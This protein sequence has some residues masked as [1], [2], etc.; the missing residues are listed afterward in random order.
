MSEQP[1]QEVLMRWFS[2]EDRDRLEAQIRTLTAERDELR[3]DNSRHSRWEAEAAQRAYDFEKQLAA[4]T[5][6]LRTIIA[7]WRRSCELTRAEMLTIRRD[8]QE[9]PR[10][11]IAAVEG[12]ADDLERALL[13]LTKE[14]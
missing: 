6:A 10:Y 4:L 1:D 12:C 11:G 5:P 2:N 9:G 8:H 13:T 14:P 3:L 7:K